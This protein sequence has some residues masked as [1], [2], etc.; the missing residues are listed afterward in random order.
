MRLN[1]H[2]LADCAADMVFVRHLIMQRKRRPD[3]IRA[4]CVRWNVQWFTI[5]GNGLLRSHV[6]DGIT[7]RR[8]RGHHRR[9]RR[10]ADRYA[11]GLR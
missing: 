9:R 1:K 4:A 2:E 5:D 8:G 6:M 7:S 3:P 11:A 10:R